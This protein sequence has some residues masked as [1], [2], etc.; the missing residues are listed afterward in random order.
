MS[1]STGE[2]S[3]HVISK[4]GSPT[5]AGAP[6]RVFY[7]GDPA[8]GFMDSGWELLKETSLSAN[9]G[10]DTLVPPGEL[11]TGLYLVEFG[12]DGIDKAARQIYKKDEASG[13][14]AQLN[15]TGFFL[16]AKTSVTL[17]VEDPA[18]CNHLVRAQPRRRTVSCPA[19]SPPLSAPLIRGRCCRLA[20]RNS[21][22]GQ[23]SALTREVE[24]SACLSACAL[25]QG[26]THVA[27]N[28]SGQRVTTHTHTY[29][30]TRPCA[31]PD[32]CNARPDRSTRGAHRG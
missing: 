7:H 11:K 24:C 2:I 5:V 6:V 9:G 28:T 20:T 10:N 21:R 30:H 4:L 3:A 18:S 1:Q 14:F 26:K 15:P 25:L 23:A 27:D 16:A 29:T 32:A 17:K 22:S 12:F 19:G 8:A 13:E 31:W